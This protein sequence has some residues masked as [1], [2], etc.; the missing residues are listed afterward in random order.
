MKK[1][2]R[3]ILILITIIPIAASCISAGTDEDTDQNGKQPNVVEIGINT[4]ITH[5]VIDGFG[6]FGARSVWWDG[7]RD[8]LFSEEWARMIIEDLGVTIWRNEYYPPQTSLSPQDAD[9]E[10]QRPVVEGLARTAENAG[11]DLK[12]IFSVWSPPEIMKV[13]ISDDGNHLPGSGGKNRLIEEPHPGGTKWG[14]TLSPDMY[15][16]FGNWLAD[17][18]GLY[19]DLGV[20]IYAISPQNEPLFEQFYNSC[21]Y[22]VDWYAE[23]LE[24]AMPVVRKRYPDIN[25][26]GSEN[27]LGMEGGADR[28]WFYHTELMR[29]QE[30]L[31][32]LDI[33]AVHGYVDGINPT[34]SSTAAQNWRNHYR[35][36]AETTGKPVW[37][38]ETSGYHDHWLT[39]SG[40]AGALDLGLAI[41]AALHYGNVSAWLWWQGSDANAIN[42]Y[43][44]MQTE[45]N[46]GKRYY[47]SKQ[48][49]RYIRPGAERVDVEYN[50]NN[51]VFATAFVH[52][53]MDTFTIVAVNTNN[54]P[55]ILNLDGEQLP[56]N[57]QKIVTAAS[58][59]A[60]DEGMVESENIM[61]PAQSIVTLVH[62]NVFK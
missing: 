48:F 19:K 25:I 7:N 58:Q 61:L 1:A 60:V 31:K 3:N 17:G 53:E 33:W 56:V 32:Q 47:V 2:M 35:E 22:R 11:V 59:N 5:Q 40:R 28:Q 20:D 8:N 15:D 52:R 62:G 46:P 41:H 26:F 27:M 45:T 42:E 44:L 29:H 4:N 13:S 14:G 49:Y 57:Y 18:I 23:M 55:V 24:N 36:F 51:G 54:E 16:D 37:M 10:K 9:W 6:F 34:E 43:N 50:D 21:Y 39:Q 12:M 38:T 30:A